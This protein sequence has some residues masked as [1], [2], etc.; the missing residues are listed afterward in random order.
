MLLQFHNHN[1]VAKPLHYSLSI[2]LVEQIKLFCQQWLNGCQGFDAYTSGT[3]GNPK[4][5]FISRT[6]ALASVS[7]TKHALKLKREYTS[8]LCLDINT[9]AGKMM[10]VRSMV[11]GM[12]LLVVPLSSSPLNVLDVNTNFDFIALSPMQLENSINDASSRSKIEQAQLV[13]VGGAAIHQKMMNQIQDVQTAIYHSYGMTETVSHVALKLLNTKARMDFYKALDGVHINVDC[14]SCLTINAAVTNYETIITND[15]V[16]LHNS[17]EFEVIG[18]ADFVVNSGGVKISPEEIEHILSPYIQYPFFVCGIAHESLG[19][20]LV[21][22]I[23]WA[24]KYSFS[25]PNLL[26]Q[27]KL[28]CPK[29]KNPKK[30]IFASSFVYSASNKLNRLASIKNL[31][32]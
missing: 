9:I 15:L 19:Q 31:I 3:T 10:L 6:Q 26:A 1:L 5:I 7:L 23:E 8:L 13:L 29:Y 2:D 4:K 11:I 18:R 14:R 20:E 32:D 25:E 27:C 12:D 21:L 24:H 22:V 30:I 17:R 28:I 16:K